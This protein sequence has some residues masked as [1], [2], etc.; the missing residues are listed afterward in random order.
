MNEI[1]A[2]LPMATLEVPKDDSVVDFLE[3][4]FGVAGTSNAEMPDD[5][6]IEETVIVKSDD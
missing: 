5:R 6:D 3:S 2:K 4:Y 1:N